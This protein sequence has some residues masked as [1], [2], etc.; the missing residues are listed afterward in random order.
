[1][2]LC[3]CFKREGNSG[4]AVSLCL[5]YPCSVDASVDPVAH[6][7]AVWER[8]NPDLKQLSEVLGCRPSDLRSVEDVEKY[9]KALREKWGYSVSRDRTNVEADCSIVR[10]R[11]PATEPV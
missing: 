1:M 2:A 9:A 3:C 10:K 4:S 5:G 7:K 11:W 8:S 6:A